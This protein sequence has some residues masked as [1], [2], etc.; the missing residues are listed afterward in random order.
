MS[1]SVILLLPFARRGFPPSIANATFLPKGGHWE[2][3]CRRLSKAE[4]KPVAFYCRRAKTN[5]SGFLAFVT[6]THLE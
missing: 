5:S 4:N 3:N 2:E 1:N 6:T